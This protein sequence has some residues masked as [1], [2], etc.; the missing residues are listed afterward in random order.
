MKLPFVGKRKKTKRRP[1]RRRGSGGS[2]FRDY[3]LIFIVVF[4]LAFG[5]VML[6]STSSYVAAARFNGDSSYYFARQL[7]FTLIGLLGMI[8]VSFIPYSFWRFTAPYLYILAILLIIATI[9][10]GTAANG[11]T[12]WLIV[13]GV[14]IQPAEIAKVA[15]IALT[16]CLIENLGRKVNTFFGFIKLNLKH[17]Y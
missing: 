9:P 10:F 6:Y 5:L 17:S 15:I 2:A 1:G 3:S 12:R 16:A 13:S 8:V 11:A 14:S 7:K 4:L